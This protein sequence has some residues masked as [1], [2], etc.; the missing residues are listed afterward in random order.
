MIK[1]IF[2]LVLAF[3]FLVSCKTAKNP[4]DSYVGQDGVYLNFGKVPDIKSFMTLAVLP[5]HIFVNTRY[6]N[7]ERAVNLNKK[8]NEDEIKWMHYYHDLFSK[9]PGDIT[10]NL[11]PGDSTL[12]LMK[13]AGIATNDL[14]YIDR[15]RLLEILKVDAVLIHEMHLNIYTSTTED[16]LT[17]TAMVALLAGAASTG[18]IPR[19]NFSKSAS[20]KNK[21]FIKV[22]GKDVEHPLWSYYGNSPYSGKKLPDPNEKNSLTRLK[23]LG[24]PFVR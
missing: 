14:P 23:L 22:Y 5:A 20:F 4:V 9:N 17:T 15:Q 13:N 1:H 10:V 11:Q 7:T 16:I 12:S 3:S 2:T 8:A 19:G 18:G 24:F 6:P 21:E